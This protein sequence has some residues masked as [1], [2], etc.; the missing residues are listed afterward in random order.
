M[1]ENK[2]FKKENY[3]LSPLPKDEYEDCTFVGCIFS[4]TD[5]SAFSFIDCDF[6]DCD[7]SSATIYDT[8]FSDV[9]FNNCKL[10]GLA[11]DSA[12][13]FTF[14]ATFKECQLDF[15]SFYQRKLK[16]Q[17]FIDCSLKEVD[18]SETELRH[19][20]FNNCNLEK[21]VFN[22]SNLEKANF[23]TAYNYSIDPERNKVKKATF[24]KDGISGLLLK[25][26]LDILD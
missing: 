1:N 25:Y 14:S 7:L 11:F 23:S 16:N 8:L 12:N 26:D 22:D 9:Q 24:S 4:N 20:K 15:S 21:S 19:A 3:T 13:K 6:I 2:T 18:F 17:Q 5:L 10:L